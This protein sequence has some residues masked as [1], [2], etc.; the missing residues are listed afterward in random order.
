MEE[1]PLGAGTNVRSTLLIK[2]TVAPLATNLVVTTDR[3]LYQLELLADASAEA[4]YQSLV[5]WRYTDRPIAVGGLRWEGASAADAEESPTRASG[6]AADVGSLDFNY[7]IF[8]KKRSRTPRWYPQQVFHDG[9]KT[10]IRFGP[11]S[12]QSEAPP[13]FAR[14]GGEDTL[15]NYRVIGDTY[16]VDRVLDVAVLKIGK[17]KADQVIIQYEGSFFDRGGA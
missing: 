17:D 4:K 14:I 2:P 10:F 15:I 5:S 11:H 12:L 13:L 8:A 3:R 6:I 16:V 7:K 1:V 9:A